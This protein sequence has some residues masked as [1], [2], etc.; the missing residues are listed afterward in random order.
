MLSNF[1]PK[2][3][4]HVCRSKS[5]CLS[6]VHILSE[7]SLKN[8]WL[9]HDKCRAIS[10]CTCAYTVLALRF[11]QIPFN[12]AGFSLATLQCCQTVEDPSFIVQPRFNTA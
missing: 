1:Q 11:L 3:I 10:E 12:K 8:L 5:V 4:C 7:V 2:C 9:L 6:T